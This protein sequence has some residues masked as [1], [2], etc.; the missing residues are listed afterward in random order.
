MTKQKISSGTVQHARVPEK[1]MRRVAL[2]ALALLALCMVFAAPVAAEDTQTS[3]PDDNNGVITLTGNVVLSAQYHVPDDVNVIDGNGY[4]ISASDDWS[5]TSNEDKHLLK[6]TSQSNSP[7]TIKNVTFENKGKAYGVL[8]FDTGADIQ[9][10][11]ED[12]VINASVYTGLHLNG[13]NVSVTNLQVSNSGYQSIDL[14]SGLGVDTASSLYLAGKIELQDTFPIVLDDAHYDNAEATPSVSG[15]AGFDCEFDFFYEFSGSK[16]HK[17]IWNIEYPSGEKAAVEVLNDDENLI[18]AYFTSFTQV[19][20]N[21]VYGDYVNLLNNVNI[22]STVV[23]ETIVALDLNGWGIN[24]NDVDGYLFEVQEGGTLALFNTW[25]GT[26]IIEAQ[27]GVKVHTGGNFTA[28]QTPTEWEEETGKIILDVKGIGVSVYGHQEYQ[29]TNDPDTLVII[30]ANT[31]IKTESHGIVIYGESYDTNSAG[32]TGCYG[33]GVLVNGDINCVHPD[34]NGT[35]DGTICISTNG[36]ITEGNAVIGLG[37]DAELSAATGNTGVVNADDAPAIYSAG[38]A[39]WQIDGA[40]LSGDEAISMKQGYLT[41]NDGSFTASGNYYDPSAAN[42][43]GTEM[44]GAA[45]S[46]TNTYGEGA[47][48]VN[49]IIKG[50]AFRS[51]KGHAI[52]AGASDANEESAGVLTSL[53]INEPVLEDDDVPPRFLLSFMSA[54]GKDAIK[55]NNLRVDNEDTE[56]NEATIV[57]IS[58]GQYTTDVNTAY[59]A[60]NYHVDKYEEFY[61]V[62][63]ERLVTIS[64]FGLLYGVVNGNTLA[65]LEDEFTPTKEGYTFGG[66]Y[67]DVD[68]TVKVDLNAPVTSDITLYGK[69]TENK[70]PVTDDSSSTGSKPGSSSSSSSSSSSK[71]TTPTEPETPVVPETPEAGEVTVE[72]EVTDGGEVELETPA[73]GGSAAADE[74]ETK[75]TSVVLPTGTEGKV[76][77]VPISEQAAPAG[78]ETQTKK[79]FEINVPNYEKGKPATIKFQMTVAELEADGKT[80]AQV[81]LWHFDEETGEWT[82]LVTSY[83]IVDGVV[84]FEAI[85]ND[86]S[87]FA[88]IYEDAPAEEP[89]EEPVETPAPILAVLA[90]LGA[91]VVLRRK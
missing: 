76:E 11:L 3:M 32:A 8:F 70:K 55:L 2:A 64:D 33:V 86:F 72:T 69:W 61:I 53:L 89:T 13:A 56:G 74:D 49:V 21:L 62:N 71:P 19:P 41:I 68:C 16:F 27:N 35:Y 10:I 28:L 40:Q 48:G 34:E 30:E 90:G 44:T 45:I 20:E 18:P 65:F 75:I 82:K 5:S 50:G 22:G 57:E 39:I 66:W 63:N 67:T 54:S 25:G 87:P 29:G 15:D 51:E 80:A 58:A 43:D 23:I 38:Y 7:V 36:Y 84:Y 88:I 9:H 6:V 73:A 37:P 83:V 60:T 31:E 1:R 79:V 17:R 42:N 78:K 77:F 4:T 91:A 12:V 46:I 59:L 24:G 52:F 85:T 81:A 47:S 14:S 26:S